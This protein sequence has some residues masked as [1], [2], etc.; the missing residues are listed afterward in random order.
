MTGDALGTDADRA[1]ASLEVPV[2]EK[3]LDLAALAGEIARHI[4]AGRQP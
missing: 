3:P 1:L 2:F 4:A